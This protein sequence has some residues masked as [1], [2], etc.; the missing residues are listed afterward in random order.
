MTMREKFGRLGK[1]SYNT[2]LKGITVSGEIPGAYTL[3]SEMMGRH[4]AERH[5]IQQNR[6][7]R[8]V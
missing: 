3:L 6:E 2:I 4:H 8:R 1:V 5:L 7:V